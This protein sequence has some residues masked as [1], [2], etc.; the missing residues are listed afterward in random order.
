VVCDIFSSKG[1]EMFGFTEQ[2]VEGLLRDSI[3]IAEVKTKNPGM[4][5]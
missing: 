3:R 5:L 4:R 2:E 1:D